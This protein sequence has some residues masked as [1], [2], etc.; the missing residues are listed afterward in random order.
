[1]YSFTECIHPL[2]VLCSVYVIMSSRYQTF[3]VGQP[4]ISIQTGQ[5]EAK[6]SNTSPNHLRPVEHIHALSLLNCDST[7]PD[8]F[9]KLQ[10][11]SDSVILI[12]L[13]LSYKVILTVIHL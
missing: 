1:M 2:L 6:Y 7:I 10:T 11:M 3:A 9:N 4:I 12:R 13:K 5:F 8:M